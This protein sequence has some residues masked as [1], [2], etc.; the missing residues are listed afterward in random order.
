LRALDQ[1]V[2]EVARI[3]AG[4]RVLDVGCGTGRLTLAAARAAG[5]SG[6][7]V[8]IDPS[9]EMIELATT[10]GARAGSSAV[11]RVGAIEAIPA[12]AEHFEVVLASL[13]LHHLPPTLQRRGLAE[14]LR[15]LEPGGRFVASDFSARPRHGVGHFFWMLG[16]ARGAE[17]AEHLATLASE[18][19]FEDVRVE[20]TSSRGLCVLSGAKPC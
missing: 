18:A 8:G 17:H 14:I 12:P 3:P 6:E 9:S 19:G 4:A 15:V 5:P 7:T 20:R 13:M 2:L 11:F 16:L 10:K 1:R